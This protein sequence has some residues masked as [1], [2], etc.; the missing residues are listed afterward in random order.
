MSIITCERVWFSATVPYGCW[1]HV[2]F[3]PRTSSCW[4]VSPA[5]V[6]EALQKGRGVVLNGSLGTGGHFMYVAGLNP[7]GTFI[8]CDPWRPAITRM[9]D[10]E[11]DHFAHNQPGKGGM[12]EIWR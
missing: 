7:D 1:V 8:I 4:S 12:I 5:A 6:R 3:G 11:L 2:P 10:R 9:T